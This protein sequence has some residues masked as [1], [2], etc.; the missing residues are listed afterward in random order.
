MLRYQVVFTRNMD[1]LTARTLY[2]SLQYSMVIQYAIH[3][4]T[5]QY[6]TVQY[7]KVQQNSVPNT[8]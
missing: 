8:N 6:N 1:N 2:L 7:S 5:I 3:Y 4:S